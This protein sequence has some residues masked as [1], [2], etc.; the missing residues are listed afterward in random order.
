MVNLKDDEIL[1]DYFNSPEK[2]AKLLIR[3]KYI[4][5]LWIFFIILGLLFILIYYLIF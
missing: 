2:K 3:I 5:L 4:Y 1:S